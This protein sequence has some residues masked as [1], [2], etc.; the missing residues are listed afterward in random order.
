MT[1]IEIIDYLGTFAFAISGI[2]LASTKR[3][4]LFGALVIGFVTAVGGGTM[5]DLMLGI[6]PFWMQSYAYLVSTIIALLF[7]LIFRRFLRRLNNH[8][9]I[10]DTIG[11]GLFTLVGI[12]KSLIY[13]Q[14][15]WVAII[16]GIMSGVAGGIIRDM[17]INEVP[18]IF[19]K[20]IYAFA[21]LL[22]GFVYY[23]C[24]LLNVYLELAGVLCVLSVIISR[25][26]AVKYKIS[27]PTLKEENYV[28]GNCLCD[29]RQKK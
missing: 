8:F 24:M 15:M 3:F 9:F 6:T 4:D 16:M 27:L 22:G 7:V 25:L 2:R 5:R 11:L 20:E 12:E 13:E 21:C 26:L 1:F 14:E 23:I 19:R 29:K 18:L 28:V 17:L 10:F